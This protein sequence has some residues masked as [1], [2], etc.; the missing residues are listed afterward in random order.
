MERNYKMEIEVVEKGIC[1][2]CPKCKEMIE[3]PATPNVET[4]WAE[5]LAFNLYSIVANKKRPCARCNRGVRYQ[6]KEESK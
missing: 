4:N 1:Y 6:F 2:E 3:F 5:R